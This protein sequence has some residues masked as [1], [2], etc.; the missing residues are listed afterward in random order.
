MCRADKHRLGRR[1]CWLAITLALA[2][3]LGSAP[4][5]AD[6]QS[7]VQYTVTDL[8]ALAE[9][10]DPRPMATSNGG[11][12]V[13]V[14]GQYDAVL[15]HR[16]S[17]ID[18]APGQPDAYALA[19]NEWGQIAG[20]VSNSGAVLW[21]DGDIVEL[22]PLVGGETACAFG[23]NDSGVVVGIAS[24]PTP[25]RE[26]NPP[27]YPFLW[28]DLNGNNRTDFGET[29]F[30]FAETG[31]A[32]DINNQGVI[33]G[34]RAG[35]AFRMFDGVIHD[36]GTLGGEKSIGY[37]VSEVGKIAGTAQLPD[38]RYHGFLWGRSGTVTTMR[39]L[40]TLPGF[41]NSYAFALN[42]DGTVVGKVSAG[43][44]PQRRHSAE[45][46]TFRLWPYDCAVRFD[47]A[48]PRALDTLIAPGSGWKILEARG[49]DEA[50]NIVGTGM[51]DGRWHAV[52]LNKL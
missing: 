12:V 46:Y 44:P 19:V 8:G 52:R 48:G 18:L 37:A 4:V 6:F 47:S 50:G 22:G 38:G 2:W 40:G 49:I 20:R 9:G 24:K 7:T 27:Y 14:S 15:W 30:L 13:G 35:R 39:D 25:D 23:I 32:R 33:T 28:K 16:G 34:Q 29:Q 10:L 31:D 17:T 41:N 5:G 36:L 3:M 11:R 45:Y 51:R 26:V 42:A 43:L 21:S 1:A